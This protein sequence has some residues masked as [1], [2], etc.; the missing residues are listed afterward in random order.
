MEED[1]KSKLK[2]YVQF[3]VAGNETTVY[4]T[5]GSQ[6]TMSYHKKWYHALSRVIP[7]Y[8]GELLW[9]KSLRSLTIKY[10]GYKTVSIQMVPDGFGNFVSESEH[11]HLV[12]H[13]C[14][15][16]P[17]EEFDHFVGMCQHVQVELVKKKLSG[18]EFSRE[19]ETPNWGLRHHPST[20]APHEQRVRRSSSDCWVG[21]TLPPKYNMQLLGGTKGGTDE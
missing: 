8:L 14:I 16:I 9:V 2:K 20:Q 18:A 7:R 15:H 1:K 6:I 17:V 3:P 4:Q 11:R 13:F 10:G 12:D 5:S 19:W 21:E